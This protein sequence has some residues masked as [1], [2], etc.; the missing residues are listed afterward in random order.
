MRSIASEKR[1]GSVA[2]ERA[3]KHT[4]ESRKDYMDWDERT[5]NE[6]ARGKASEHKPETDADIVRLRVWPH[7][8]V[9]DYKSRAKNPDWRCMHCLGN[10]ELTDSIDG[11]RIC[12]FKSTRTDVTREVCTQCATTTRKRER[13]QGRSNSRRSRAVRHS[14]KPDRAPMNPMT[15]AHSESKPMAALTT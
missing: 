8:F 7:V 6:L 11:A 2:S 15:S 10:P 4:A 1:I 5:M 12:F 13:G 3:T 9:R 14:L